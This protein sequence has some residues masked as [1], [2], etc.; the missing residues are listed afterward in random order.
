M[1]TFQSNLLNFRIL[2]RNPAAAAESNGTTTSSELLD[3]TETMIQKI[4][5]V[6]PELLDCVLRTDI[7]PMYNGGGE[8]MA[9][10]YNVPFW[11]RLPLDPQLLKA[12]ENGQ[13]FVAIYPHSNATQILFNFCSRIH[14]I[15]PVDM[16]S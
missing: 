16:S 2:K 3:C 11:G 4:S 13:A 5:E 7:F 8:R 10:E 12:C 1:G 14:H 6:C 9:Q 15:L